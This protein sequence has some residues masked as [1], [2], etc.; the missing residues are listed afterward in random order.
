VP[1]VRIGV[2]GLN[3][4]GSTAPEAG[5]ELVR[6]AEELGY[7]SLWAGEHVVLPSPRVAP[8]P[9]EPTDPIL[10]P[11]VWLGFV[12]AVTTRV[13]LATG[14]V[15]LP[16]RHPLVLAKEA[17]T[18]DVLSGGRLLL[19]VGAGYLE[20]ELAAIGIPMAE[21]GSRTDEHL[22]VMRALWTEP[23]PVS[24]HGR[25]TD[26]SGID[27]HPRPVQEGGPRIVVGGR[28]GAA[29]RR[30]VAR[31]H[32]WYGFLHTVEDAAAQVAGLER[33]AAS[34]PRPANLGR[35]EVSVTPVGRLDPD[36]VRAYGDVGVDRLV[37]FA[38]DR[39]VDEV[40]TYLRE[41]APLLDLAP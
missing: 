37:L 38:G 5:L 30:A 17:A 11:I 36:R 10:D 41:Q 29:H 34:T 28:S 13:L 20:P 24:F 4:F 40:A 15:I 21:R 39:P 33:A 22:D 19:G 18:L 8:A 9:M 12:A 1:P 35:L 7:D 14:I 16:Q 6:L 25:Y 27:A 23:G 3:S 31:G 26:V 2:F 32:G